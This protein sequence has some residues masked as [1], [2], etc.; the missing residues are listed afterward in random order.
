MPQKIICIKIIKLCPKKV[1]ETSV[2][3]AVD[4]QLIGLLD[5]DPYFFCNRFKKKY[6]NMALLYKI[7]YF[8]NVATPGSGMSKKSGSESGMKN[9]DN[10]FECLETIFWVKIFK[11]FEA[12]PG[13][14]ILRSGMEKIRIRDKHPGS[15]FDSF[16]KYIQRSRILSES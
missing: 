14:N 1:V 5:P 15:V 11:F 6:K 16:L 7:S 4:T 13:W 10:I 3:D 2:P 9:P 8:S 12:D